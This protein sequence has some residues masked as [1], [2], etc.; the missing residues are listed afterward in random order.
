MIG[1]YRS[2]KMSVKVDSV[3][4]H[5]GSPAWLGSYRHPG[6]WIKGRGFGREAGTVTIDG[7][8]Q[9]V[10]SW[11][12]GRILIAKTDHDPFW[13]PARAPE[14]TVVVTTAKRS[15]LAANDAGYAM[16]A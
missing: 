16:A 3:Q 12:P 8:A 13:N 1:Y 7:T 4:F 15:R 2:K 9:R 14:V 5:G 6:Y 11:E 10:V